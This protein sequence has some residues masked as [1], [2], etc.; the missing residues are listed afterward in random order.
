MGEAT[1][2][3]LQRLYW[4]CRR[5]SDFPGNIA[6]ESNGFV[7]TEGI[8]EGLCVKVPSLD[9]K[10]ASQE[11]RRPVQSF[12][13]NFQIQTQ[14]SLQA[15]T[16]PVQAIVARQTV[17]TLADSLPIEYEQEQNS[18]TVTSFELANPLQMDI[19]EQFDMGIQPPMSEQRRSIENVESDSHACWYN[20][21]TE[22][23]FGV[24]AILD[25]SSCTAP[26]W[27]PSSHNFC[28]TLHID[29]HSKVVANHLSHFRN[30]QSMSGTM[31]D[32]FLAPWPGFGGR[33]SISAYYV[34]FCKNGRILEFIYAPTREAWLYES[35]T[36]G[37][38]QPEMPLY[39]LCLFS[40]ASKMYTV[41][42]NLSSSYIR[43][44]ATEIYFFN[45]GFNL[46]IVDMDCAD[47]CSYVW[48]SKSNSNLPVSY[49][50]DQLGCF[51]SHNQLS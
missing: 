44:G 43:I 7:I 20:S 4:A 33:P 24:E 32:G 39:Y 25:M 15:N 18:S 41:G 49:I 2:E 42:R 12:E 17:E 47:C 36:V 48:N 38:A 3:A 31:H 11:F 50:G 46:D 34:T 35:R 8:L 16:T 45:E 6:D 51:V 29:M 10:G 14:P 21:P 28:E 5:K 9:E 22:P 30:D 27:A 40:R 1:D 19:H 26:V 37:T 13:T 23:L